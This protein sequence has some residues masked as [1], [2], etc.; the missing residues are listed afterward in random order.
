MNY[1]KMLPVLLLAAC[2]DIEKP[3]DCEVKEVTYYAFN[4]FNYW[5][6]PTYTILCI[7]KEEGKNE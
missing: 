5:V 6:G 1:F 3:K 2:G 7:V 4:A